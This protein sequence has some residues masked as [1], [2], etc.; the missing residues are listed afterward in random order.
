MNALAQNLLKQ[1][2]D[3]TTGSGNLAAL[4]SKALQNASPEPPLTPGPDT[5]EHVA[6]P[7][8]RTPGA[9]DDD[10]APLSRL[11][12]T[13]SNS[14]TSSNSS[15]SSVH[16]WE[17]DNGGYLI[18]RRRP[19]TAQ[20]KADKR[21]V[22]A[23]VMALL[24][25]QF[26]ALHPDV[27]NPLFRR[28]F[29]RARGPNGE[30]TL[31]KN[32]DI[33]LPVFKQHV[34]GILRTLT[35]RH[36]PLAQQNDPAITY[37]DLHRR[38]FFAALEVCKRRRSN[39]VQSWRPEIHGS[40]LPLIY[41]GGHQLPPSPSCAA[42]VPPASATPV[43]PAPATPV[44]P[45]SAT[46]V[47]P[48][49]ATPVPPASLT[50]DPVARTP[51][52]D[53]DGVD[54]PAVCCEK[55]CNAELAKKD[56][57]PKGDKWGDDERVWCETC[58]IKRR[59]EMVNEEIDDPDKRAKK[60]RELQ[61]AR[62]QKRRAAPAESEGTT[63]KR[64]TRRKIVKCKW[65]KSTSH[66]TKRSKNCPFNAN[67]VATVTPEPPAETVAPAATVTST[68]PVTSIPPVTSTPPAETV[69]PDPPVETVAPAASV[70]STPP[71]ATA[72]PVVPP[73]PRVAPAPL[74]QTFSVGDNVLAVVD[75][76]SY[77]AQVVRI[78]GAN[79][80]VYFVDNGEVVVIDVSCLRPERFPTPKRR[81]FLNLEFYF[82]GAPD[83]PAGRWKVRRVVRNEY[84]CTRLT[85]GTPSST[86]LER[87][88]V[89]YVMREIISQHEFHRNTR[90]SRHRDSSF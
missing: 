85:G 42:P 32:K 78:R 35:L 23:P 57:F 10:G 63:A 15:I 77:L 49:S 52:A 75:R 6:I 64:R 67:Y 1:L 16:E 70:T 8:L 22:T 41:S 60:M 59:E 65:C 50:P 58:W 72:T 84:I 9:E 44:P 68:P 56:Q 62:P 48:A 4:L 74:P 27:R 38:F 31:K 54:F 14:S 28:K 36:L 45:A 69:T 86:N 90:N 29:K 5:P 19:P 20:L 25:S 88:D 12:S 80:E 51:S 47:P 66:K 13:A 61:R 37:H 2:G 82:D 30:R 33:V 26:L 55:N 11:S 17:D 24:D 34:R 73:A 53:D 89:G 76:K 71:A 46:P 43:P 87:F 39:H 79:H 3:D 21:V 7:S 40:H 83:L 18:K 81:E